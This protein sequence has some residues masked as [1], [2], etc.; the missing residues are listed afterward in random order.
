VKAIRGIGEACRALN[1]PITGGN[2][3]LYNETDGKA[4]YPTPVIGV[5]G[6]LEDASQALRRSFE[7]EGDA[8]ML[9]GTT[10]HDIGGSEYLKVVHGRV[11]GR[12]PRLSLDAEKKLYAAVLE[13]SHAGLLHSAHDVSDGGLAVALAEC[14]FIGE[15]PGLGG[16]FDLPSGGLAPD[17]A[18]FSE[19]PSRMIVSTSSPGRVEEIARRHGVPCVRLGAVGGDRFQI[20]V[21]GKVVVDATVATLHHAWMGLERLLG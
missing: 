16:I 7:S 10:A 18:L 21:D 8:V 19:S 20:D 15:E 5:V 13:S 1:V 14:G 2:V 9:L 12:P 11:A 3:S 17:V 6:L 4:I